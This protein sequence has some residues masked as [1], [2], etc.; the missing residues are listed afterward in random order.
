M[1]KYIDNLS[2]IKSIYVEFEKQEKIIK[3]KADLYMDSISQNKITKFLASKNL[4]FVKWE[5]NQSQKI[6]EVLFFEDST[7]VIKDTNGYNS[8]K[9]F[10][11]N[12]NKISQEIFKNLIEYTLRKKPNYVKKINKLLETDNYDIEKVNIMITTFLNN[13]NILKNKNFNLMEELTD[14]LKSKELL[15][16]ING[17][18]LNRA[19]IID[20]KMNKIVLEYK[21]D[22]LANSILSKKYQHLYNSENKIYFKEL[23]DLNVNKTV[24]QD[25]IGK[26]LAS[27]ETPEKLGKAILLL[28]N[29][30][31]NFDIESVKSKAEVLNSK[32]CIET[33]DS[34]VIRINDFN[35]SK[36]LGIS[37]WCISREQSYFDSYSSGKSQYFYF[38]FTKDSKSNLSMIGFTIKKDGEQYTAHQKD[39]EYIDFSFK[40][41]NVFEQTILSDIDKYKLSPEKIKELET[42]QV[43]VKK[44]KIN[45]KI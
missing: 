15:R 2:I 22:Q 44:Q 28:I 32:I 40:Y 37:S 31:N 19:E 21:V 29:S 12:Y 6:K 1:N 34:L 16:D 20:D 14:M 27:Y 38:D 39:D 18:T 17:Y 8:I 23:Y 9:P 11:D 24:L 41:K 42:S 13:E 45:N 43:S 35:A 26:K 25:N 33:E 10:D 30:I 5:F 36:N 3:T 4:D 7:I